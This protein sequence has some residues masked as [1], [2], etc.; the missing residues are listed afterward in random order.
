MLNEPK[1]LKVR[2][3]ERGKEIVNLRIPIALVKLVYEFV[4][5]KELESQGI[6]LENLISIASEVPHGKI[7]EIDDKKT[8]TRVEIYL[9]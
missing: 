5:K 8:K 3:V 9:E 6:D 4:P 1:F 2:V 7:V